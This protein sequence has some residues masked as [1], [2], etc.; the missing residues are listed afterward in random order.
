MPPLLPTSNPSNDGSSSG[1]STASP[2]LSY[3]RHAEATG[4]VAATPA[5]VFEYLDR[6]ERLS[7]HMQ[8]SS[9]QLAGATMAIETDTGRGQ[10]VGSRIS[11]S[12]RM[13]GLRLFV[14]AEVKRRQVPLLK[15]WE[16]I[17]EPRLLVLGCYRMSV[18]V[19]P[20]GS[21]SHVT[22]AIDYAIP[23]KPP[24]RWLGMLLG[25]MYARWCVTQMIR[26]LVRQSAGLVDMSNQAS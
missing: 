3:S 2:P 18:S 22:I 11:L 15:V 4:D 6:P 1:V 20:R 8:R 12:G 23:E 16:T 7:A 19:S 14:E 9:W 17:G 5:A 21:R 13:L 10:Q 24:T 26:D 25:A